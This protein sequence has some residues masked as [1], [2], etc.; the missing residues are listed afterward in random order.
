MYH[1]IISCLLGCLSADR[2][3]RI[4]PMA[5]ATPAE[6]RAQIGRC[7]SLIRSIYVE[8]CSG[9]D[10][11]GR[12]T[13]E[14]YCPHRILVA[15][16]DGDFSLVATHGYT[17]LPW[18]QDPF[19]QNAVLMKT[20]FVNDNP[21]NRTCLQ[22]DIAGD[23]TLP[24]SAPREFFMTATGVWPFSHRPAPR[25]LGLGHPFM[26]KDIARSS[27]YDCVRRYQEKIDG[28]WCHVLE[29]P[30]VDRL[31]L[32]VERGASLKARECFAPDGRIVQRF[33][34]LGHTELGA[35]IWLPRWIKNVRYDYLAPSVVSQGE[36]LRSTLITCLVIRANDPPAGVFSYRPAPG[37]ICLNGRD[38]VSLVADG[39]LNH[40]DHMNEWIGAYASHESS[41][42]S[43][44]SRASGPAVWALPGLLLSAG[45]WWKRRH[46][47][48]AP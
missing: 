22:F 44:W 40:L 9:L 27:R 3:Y 47:G 36:I 7:Q 26:L 13:G 42:V 4:A 19:Q 43:F 30:G 17:T 11:S 5:T 35:G 31:W 46:S 2:S 38:G 39:E 28:R 1:I 12:T 37:T 29:C 14:E 32:D 20:R 16:F 21:I 45:L 25:Y 15:S 23:A 24:G 33:E 41:R 10:I 8:Y 34:C 6:L 48:S 18:A